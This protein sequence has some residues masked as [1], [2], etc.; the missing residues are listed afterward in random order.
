M[1]TGKLREHVAFARAIRAQLIPFRYPTVSLSVNQAC[2]D[3]GLG[4]FRFQF[5]RGFAFL[6]ALPKADCTGVGLH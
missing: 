1:R 3:A 2:G 4:L 5:I 6:A